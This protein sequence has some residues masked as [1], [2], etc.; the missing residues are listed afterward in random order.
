[1]EDPPMSSD[2][3]LDLKIRPS[4]SLYLE[5][6]TAGSLL[7]DAST[8]HLVGRPYSAGNNSTSPSSTKIDIHITA[9]NSTIHFAKATS[10]EVN[11]LNNE[12]PIELDHFAPSLTQYNITIKVSPY[13]SNGTI[14]TATTQLIR[15]PQRTDGGSVTR[16]DHLYGGLSVLKGNETDWSL[17]FPYTYYGAQYRFFEQNS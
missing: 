14:Y 12:I 13:H 4:M 5:S 8:S 16:L 6:D 11:S 1:M 9:S 2:L 3:L 10:V 17:I 15:L 7:V